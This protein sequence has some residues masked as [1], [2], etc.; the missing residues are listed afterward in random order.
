GQ[1]VGAIQGI[2]AA[3]AALDMPIVSGNVSL[4]NETDG[5]P[6]LPTPTIGAVGLIDD[7]DRAITGVVCDGH[8]A[9][10]IGDAGNHLGQ[11]ALLAEAFAREDGD[12]P[13]V[14]LEAER[15]NGE[16]I[17]AQSELIEACAD[18][19]DGGLALA[20]F[21]LAEAAGVGVTLDGSAPGALFGED[22]GRY[23]I[24]CAF[25]QA[26][27]LMVEA[28]RVDVPIATVGRFGGDEVRLG[29]SSRPLA[30]LS[31]LYRSS[32]ERALG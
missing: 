12:A 3:C 5:Q 25:D 30:E 26:E 7:L 10:L 27:T 9:L 28:A 20:A 6:I 16:F 1:F 11:S 17:L 18:L 32:F 8:V 29:R 14:D 2:G 23:L 21:E 31:A 19:S 15:R 4:Y 24:A 22:Q 13:P